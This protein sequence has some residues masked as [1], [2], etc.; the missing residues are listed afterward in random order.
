VISDLETVED[1]CWG[2]AFFG[3]GGGG[4][5]EAGVDMLA[6]AVRAGRQLV[7]VSADELPDE[8]WTCWAI[9]L[10]GK[11]PDEPPPPDELKRFGLSREEFPT[12]VPRL[13]E[14]ARELASYAGVNL[15]ALVSMELSSAATSATI[16]TGLELGI[17]TIDGDYVGRAIPELELSKMQLIGR[18]PTPIVMVDR[19]GNRMVLKSAVGAAMADRIGRMVS[20][21]AYGRGIATTGHLVQ[22]RDARTAL[23]PGS[24]VRALEVG[25]ALRRGAA[26]RGG[27]LDPLVQMTGG[28]VLFTG[29]AERVDWRSDEPYTW[30]ELTYAIRGSGKWAGST[31]RIWVKNEHHAIWRD[32]AVIGTSPDVIVVLDAETNK[33]LTTLGDVAPGRR[34][35]CF[36]MKALDP[37]WRT[38]EGRALLGPRHFGLDFDYV[39]FETVVT[40]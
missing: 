34:V 10:G 18:P 30:R 29:E 39:D 9:I 3:T 8:V 14:S 21:A 16:L 20:R 15:G 33:P 31:Y 12:I 4:R 37:A 32:E 19:W 25:G 6:P 24:L 35:V 2:L 40:S 28:H 1:F 5:V 23:V 7:L 38:P 22:I 13:V 26:Q 11:D 36:A 17:P 27:H